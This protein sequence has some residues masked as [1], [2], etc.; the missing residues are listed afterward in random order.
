[1]LADTP[2]AYWRL[3]ETSGTVAADSSGSHL[4][5]T[6]VHV[7][8]GV[9]GALAGDT[10][11]AARFNGSNGVVEVS[12]DS[13]LRLNGSW[14]IEFWARQIS[15][16]NAKPGILGKGTGGNK[17]TYSVFADS[18]GQLWLQRNNKL[19]GSGPGALAAGY[20]QFTVTYDGTR[21]RWY[22][23]G[24][25]A[26]NSLITYPSSSGNGQKLQIG[27]AQDAGDND[28]DEVALYP[29]ALSAARIA[30][31]YAAGS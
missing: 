14:T 9:A 8:L 4:D 2:I 25:L 17:N 31:H 29:S 7:T 23:N 3:G 6:F 15:F 11:K 10:D 19:V 18:G 5:G 12:N 26:T 20:K 21:V 16:M 30:A 22:V 13:V 28:I 24:V 1:M 27:A